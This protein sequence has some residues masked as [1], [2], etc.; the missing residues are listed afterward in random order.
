V[1]RDTLIGD[2]GPNKLVDDLGGG[3]RFI[4]RGGDDIIYGDGDSQPPQRGDVFDG[5]EGTDTV[6]Y[7]RIYFNRGVV[8]SLV[9]GQVTRAAYDRLRSIENA[10]GGRGEDRIFG[11]QW[12]NVLIGGFR[13]DVLAGRRGDDTG[14]GGNGGDGTDTCRGIEAAVSCEE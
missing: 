1:G 14:N 4:G 12:D 8:I 3:E 13:D 11:T 9:A 2:A 6:S 5:G 10:T 7:S